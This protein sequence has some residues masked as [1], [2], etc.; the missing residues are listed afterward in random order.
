V[1]EEPRGEGL[2]YAIG[3]LFVCPCCLGQWIG[4]GLLMTYLRE[5]RL[6]RTVAAAFTI[7]AGSDMLQ[8][9]WAAVDKRA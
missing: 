4:T 8:K 2:R 3:E 7:V 1:S 9:T 6:A 5:P